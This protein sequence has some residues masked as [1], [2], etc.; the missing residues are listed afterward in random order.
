MNTVGIIGS[1]VSGNLVACFLK[2]QFPELRVVNIGEQK[3]NHPIVGES[4]TEFSTFTLHKIGLGSLLEEQH[5]HK[6]GLTFYFKEN[7]DD[8]SCRTYAVHEAPAIPPMPSNQINRFTFDN[9]LREH[10]KNLGAETISGRVKNLS[11]NNDGT[12]SL[13]YQTTG[14]SQRN[15]QC[16]WLIDASG[17][18]RFLAKRFDLQQRPVYQRS[19]FWFRLVDFDRSILGDIRAVKASQYAYDSYY[20][21][22]HFFGRSNWIWCIPLR[23]EEHREMISIGIV[24]RPDLFST[25]IRNIDH[26]LEY[27]GQEHPVLAELV[28]SGNVDDTNLYRNYF[29][30]SKQ[31]YSE[32]GWFI[33]GDAGDAVDPLYSTG[34]VM[35]SL[36]V[37]Q[38][39][40][41]IAH[42]QKG[43]LT[44][45]FLR[46]LEST[47]KAV[48]DSSQREISELFEVMH[49]PFQSHW[50]M[51]LSSAFYFYVLLPHWLS[52]Y[53]T[54]EIGARW[55]E[56][57][58][59]GGQ[60]KRKLLLE[61][62]PLASNRRGR[63]PSEQIKNI[64]D[65]TV[66]WSL[67]KPNEKEVAKH[68]A[69]GLFLFAR[70]RFKLLKQSGWHKAAKQ[71]RICLGD[72]LLG[73]GIGL[74]FRQRSIKQSKVIQY[75]L[76]QEFRT[77]RLDQK[78]A[79]ASQASDEDQSAIVNA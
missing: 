35:T 48:R 49:D 34:L 67:W 13:D 16:R 54:N 10:A 7:I 29:Y 56:K 36:Q 26:F 9:S 23:S 18:S 71:L 69:K 75:L 21:T 5:Y 58:I 33:L 25:D 55:L 39:A 19:S 73:L 32:E 59:E 50:R 22:H 65:L 70:F 66:N 28:R 45:N 61:L 53:M 46:Q 14:G 6:Y 76:K 51:H 17:R 37:H 64:Y 47:Y 57:I 52:G 63:L 30:E 60:E 2:K 12:K 31:L 68:L 27:V 8:P 15:L 42:G 11:F 79:K 24:M 1:S 62:L 41:C 4:L 77:S 78:T 38:I 20:V 44:G 43:M 40:E 72:L 3:P 74:F